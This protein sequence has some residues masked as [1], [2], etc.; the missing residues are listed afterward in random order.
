MMTEIVDLIKGI[1]AKGTFGAP[2]VLL[3]VVNFSHIERFCFSAVFPKI[4]EN[5]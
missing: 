2:R 4:L 5:V 3:L 1:L